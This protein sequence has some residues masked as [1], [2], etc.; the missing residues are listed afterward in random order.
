[1]RR[2]GNRA[3]SHRLRDRQTA[4]KRLTKAPAQ[5]GKR[6]RKKEKVPFAQGGERNHFAYCC[7][8]L[9]VA[10]S[11]MHQIPTYKRLGSGKWT[12]SSIS[13]AFR[14]SI[15]QRFLQDPTSTTFNGKTKNFFGL[16]HFQE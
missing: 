8:A 2:R 16:R 12:H 7:S 5:E 14:V 11:N 6:K 1:M 9:G 10:G 13:N 4:L 3:I 15:Q